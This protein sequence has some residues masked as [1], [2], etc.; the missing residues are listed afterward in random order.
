MVNSFHKGGKFITS[1]VTCII[2]D[3][4]YSGHFMFDAISTGRIST[5]QEVAQTTADGLTEL[6]KRSYVSKIVKL[7]VVQGFMNIYVILFSLYKE[8]LCQLING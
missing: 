4:L 1:I 7:N 6:S 8:I 5:D 2:L 3:L